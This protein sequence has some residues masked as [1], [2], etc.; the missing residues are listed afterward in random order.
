MAVCRTCGLSISENATFCTVCGT[1]AQANA[2]PAGAP[3]PAWSTDP[4]SAAYQPSSAPSAYQPATYPAGPAAGSASRTQ[5]PMSLSARLAD[6]NAR[7]WLVIAAVMVALAAVVLVGTGHSFEVSLLV[8]MLVDFA[9]FVGCLYV[10]TQLVGYK[11]TVK[12]IIAIAVICSV[13]GLVPV[14]GWLLAAAVGFGMLMSF[15][16]AE[17]VDTL[18]IIVVNAVLRFVVTWVLM[19][20]FGLQIA[21]MHR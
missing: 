12:Q 21:L 15:T 10:A 7:I 14:I 8:F 18:I 4:A 17:W 9:C 20:A 16:S 11:I 19:M 13:V 1:P 6:P 2:A 3:R 5:G